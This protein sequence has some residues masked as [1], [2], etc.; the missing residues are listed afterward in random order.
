[1]WQTSELKTVTVTVFTGDA[2]EKEKQFHDCRFNAMGLSNL[3]LIT[4]YSRSELFNSNVSADRI[5]GGKSKD[6]VS[7]GIY[8]FLHLY[9]IYQPLVLYLHNVFEAL[10]LRPPTDLM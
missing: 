1:M 5:K 3:A 8:S 2:M 4:S 7:G 6:L 10:L 9:F